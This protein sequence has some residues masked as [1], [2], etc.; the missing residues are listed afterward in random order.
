MQTGIQAGVESGTR[1]TMRD[2][3]RRLSSAAKTNNS[4][5]AGGSAVQWWGL[6][7]SDL[8]VTGVEWGDSTELESQLTAD[9]D[10]DGKDDIT[11]WRPVPEGAYFFSI[12]SSDFTIRQTGFGQA[13][14]NPYAVGDYDG[15]GIDDPAVYRCP[16][17]FGTC[18][19]YYRQ[20]SIPDSGNYAVAWG[21]G[22][23]FDFVPFPGDFNG[24]G[25]RD[26]AIQG[27]SP[28]NPGNGIFYININ[29]TSS[30]SGVEWGLL[31]D[32]VVS[33]DF[34]GDGK[35]DFTVTRPDANS[36][37][38]WYVL[39]QDGGTQF[40]PWGDIQDFETPGDYD[41]DGRDDFAIYRWNTTDATFWVQP[42]NG[43]SYFAVTWGQPE[44][45]PVAF[46]SV[47]N[48]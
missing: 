41:G 1:G 7:S 39:E 16:E 25:R 23:E 33:G 2:R 44:D 10:G 36:V 46:L 27:E 28:S 42:S 35:S 47:G 26:F 21:V 37:L 30:F 17:T 45:R 5:Q 18:Y 43:S 31:T 19:F 8:G 14:D 29:G 12:N 34:D 9:F 15:D 22:Q 48:Q 13:F 3:L 24:D 32:R 4:L 6:N 40:V 38:W 11:V 20:S